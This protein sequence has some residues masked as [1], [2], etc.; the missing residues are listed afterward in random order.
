MATLA[1]A[2]A[3][4][5]IHAEATRP[6]PWAAPGPTVV[7]VHGVGADTG[8]WSDWRAVLGRR[9]PTVSLD[10]PGHG[11]SFR[12]TGALDWT[13]DDLV[14]LVHRAGEAAGAGRL[15]LVGESIGGTLCLAAAMDRDDVGA[16][17]T[18]STAHVGGSLGHVREWRDLMATGGIE[19]WSADM[20]GKR[21]MPGQATAERRAWFDRA[22]RASDG[23]TV[24][25]L[26][27]MLVGLDLTE[28][29]PAIRCPVLLIHP[30]SSPFI[31]LDLPVALRAGLPDA[32]LMVIPGARH[33]IA[34]SHGRTCA[35]AALDFLARR[36]IA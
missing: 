20:L 5:T 10:L 33:G 12:P 26:A 2:T 31:P 1:I 15:I 7:F 24:L 22:Q 32:E 25:A 19:G 27:D 3:A 11:R 16:V 14:A 9:F 23:E 35:D 13:F 30:D 21:F 8:I 4:G 28:R 29:L 34:C 6:A 17:V 36:G 18:A